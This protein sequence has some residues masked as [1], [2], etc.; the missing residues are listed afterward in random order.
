VPEIKE[1]KSD[2]NP[3]ALLQKNAA[4]ERDIKAFLTEVT[5]SRLSDNEKKH[6]FKVM[7]CLLYLNDN[8]S[9][10]KFQIENRDDCT[11]YSVPGIDAYG[12]PYDNFN[13]KTMRDNRLTAYHVNYPS[14][15][16]GLLEM[17]DMFKQIQGVLNKLSPTKRLEFAKKFE[18]DKKSGCL[19]ARIAK[20]LL[21]ATNEDYP[22]LDDI[23]EY[24][25]KHHGD[26]S[27]ARYAWRY[28]AD[29]KIKICAYEGAFIPVTNQLLRNYARDILADEDALT[30]QYSY[31]CNMMSASSLQ[32]DLLY[33]Y[34]ENES[35]AKKLVGWLKQQPEFKKTNNLIKSNYAISRLS[36][37]VA[38]SSEQFN[39][40]VGYNTFA[41]L[42]ADKELPE[43][44]VKLAS[45]VKNDI[46][47]KELLTNPQL[48]DEFNQRR[49]LLSNATFITLIEL[50]SSWKTWVQK[51]L[52]HIFFDMETASQIEIIKWLDCAVLGLCLREQ[53]RQVQYKPLGKEFS[54][55]LDKIPSA[56]LVPFLS[57][58][59]FN[60]DTLLYIAVLESE[61][62]FQSLLNK[63]SPE[64]LA[65]L[66]Q[67]QTKKGYTILHLAADCQSEAAFQC[68][69]EK[70]S[71]DTLASLLQLQDKD[72]YT[73]LHRVAWTQSESVFQRLLEK[74]SPEKL[75]PAIIKID[76]DGLTVLHVLL[77]KNK[78]TAVLAVLKFFDKDTFAL[79]LEGIHDS[80]LLVDFL[81]SIEDEDLQKS[82]FEFQA[83]QLLQ[84]TLEQWING[85]D[86][87]PKLASFIK[88][89]FASTADSISDEKMQ[90]YREFIL[91]SEPPTKAIKTSRS[92]IIE[93]E[94]IA[95]D[96]IKVKIIFQQGLKSWQDYHSLKK[97]LRQQLHT[98]KQELDN[99][100]LYLNFILNTLQ[101]ENAV[102]KGFGFPYDSYL[103]F[104]GVIEKYNSYS[105]IYNPI[106]EENGL[107]KI[108]K[109]EHFLDFIRQL[110]DY[111][112]RPTL[113]KVH[114]GTDI[115]LKFKYVHLEQKI[116]PY[117]SHKEKKKEK[118]YLGLKKQSFSLL[119]YKLN[120][121]L[122]GEQHSN[123]LM[124]GMLFDQELCLSAKGFFKYDR[125]TY[126][127][128]W[129]SGTD[130]EI[131]K[132]GEK[133]RAVL[134][135]SMEEM[136]E[137]VRD[138]PHEMTEILARVTREACVGICIARDTPDARKEAKSRHQILKNVLGIEVPIFI[139]NNKTQQI[140]LFDE[141]PLIK[142]AKAKYFLHK[143][144]DDLKAQNAP[145]E[146]VKEIF[147]LVSQ[148]EE[149][150]KSNPQV[151]VDY[152]NLVKNILGKPS[153]VKPS[154]FFSQEERNTTHTKHPTSS[155]PGG[156]VR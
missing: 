49:L 31:L 21:W 89:Y 33:H 94:D 149:K 40:L 25:A 117:Q 53:L 80:V 1:E 56:A 2:N 30:T 67:L 155:R 35:D 50:F 91:A 63:I 151:W 75:V 108:I 76:K 61:T 123:Q 12:N 135:G 88:N 136:R 106:R 16:K 71:P 126:E 32:G 73:I 78:R 60:E 55:I 137:F 24:S 64:T 19:D 26:L 28:C 113:R 134:L 34:F 109:P 110:K 114:V 74:T 116:V 22:L 18:F 68:L 7:N 153:T 54:M 82:I 107:I 37:Y 127:R 118:E 143:T 146:R 17:H 152:N 58:R 42:L 133:I 39:I 154:V 59:V 36:Y 51:F 120:T 132:Y 104:P 115:T 124:V 43:I 141:K 99:R 98:R 10:F 23:M 70:I 92:K 77:N 79:L 96:P 20:A 121:R 57:L 6:C 47:W 97:Y 27:I 62:T 144:L 87:S 9:L 95:K 105:A 41:N 147:D 84:Y 3:I 86:A 11:I 90:A 101:E 66:L 8:L 145:V 46:A 100:A 142:F 45:N 83:K 128:G 52:D 122:F 119:S 38:L 112:Y 93:L 138:K 13:T 44:A 150:A 85:G 29:K 14:S 103:N 139:Y 4:F 15:E 125:G 102:F 5:A 48:A 72:G 140:S 156:K 130:A 69:L 111:T 81:E 131:K 65:P 129:V 148:A